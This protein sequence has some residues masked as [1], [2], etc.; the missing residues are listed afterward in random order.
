MKTDSF[1][2]WA[3]CYGLQAMISSNDNWLWMHIKRK[4]GFVKDCYGAW[5]GAIHF[6]ADSLFGDLYRQ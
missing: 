6:D 2:R 1:F 4:Q 3:F 5:S